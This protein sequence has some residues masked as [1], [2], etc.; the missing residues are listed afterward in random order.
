MVSPPKQIK[1]LCAKGAFPYIWFDKYGK[2]KWRSLP[3]RKYFQSDEEYEHACK[4][5]EIKRKI[6]EDYHDKYLL[7]D[8]IL[9]TGCFRVFRKNIYKMHKSDISLV[10]QVSHGPLR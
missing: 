10:S 5:W 8:V 6:F 4:A 2:M 9:L 7:A 1:I 3:E